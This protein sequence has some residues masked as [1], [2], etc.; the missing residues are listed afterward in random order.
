MPSAA[1]FSTTET[2][3]NG[4]RAEIRALRP[5]DREDLLA[6]VRRTSSQSLYRRFFGVRREFSEA[7]T[8]FFLNLD[9]VKHVALIAVV[10]EVGRPVIAGGGRYITTKPGQ[11]E[12]AFAIVDQ[13]QNLGIGT[14]LLRHL[15]DLARDAGLKEFVAD[16]LAEN[17]P[18]LGVFEKS[19]LKLTTQRDLHVIHVIFQLE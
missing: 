14:A 19:G 17:A 2:L 9:F 3:H 5:E 10:D 4:Q 1:L 7:E 12:I 18:M 8:A 6:A 16:V 13:F 15:S 11:A